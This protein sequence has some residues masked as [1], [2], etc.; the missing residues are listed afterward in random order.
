[1]I[2]TIVIRN[3][4][5][6]DIGQIVETGD[7]I[8]KTEADPGINNIIGEEILEVIWGYIKTLKD[9]TVEE[10]IEITAEMKVMAEVEIGT[11]L[12]KGHFPE[13]LV[14]I[15]TTGVQATVGPGQ[16]WGQVWIETGFLPLSTNIGG[17]VNIS[18]TKD[19][20]YLIEEQARHVYRKVESGSIINADT[21]WQE[22]EQERALS[23]IDDTSRDV[24]PYKELIVN[25]AE[26]IEP[27]LTQME[28][29]SILSNTLNYIQ[30]DRHPK[31]YHS[32]SVSAVNKC[33]KT[34]CTKEEERDM[35][36]VDFGHTPDVLKEEYL[37][38]YEGIQ[39]K[40]LSTTIVDENSDLI[41]TYLGKA[42]KSD[43]NK[44]KAEEFFLISEQGYTMGKL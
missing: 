14:A 26:K 1:M 32:L 16:D 42:D 25:K 39:S 5:R 27:I 43:N 36:E 12:E 41:T 18:K 17:Q 11:D 20:W 10:S 28:Q 23:R 7:S 30:Y 9:K 2:D 6:I 35:L 8:G 13:T 44:I 29:W 37:D 21:L 4:I 40:I 33:K 3:I 31:N 22:M 19:N 24:N 15:E 34:P 38:V